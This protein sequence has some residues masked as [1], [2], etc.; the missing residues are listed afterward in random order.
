MGEP[1]F[2]DNPDAAQKITQELTAL[3][4]GIETYKNLLAKFDDTQIFLELALE[5]EDL[6]RKPTLPRRLPTS[7]TGLKRCGWKSC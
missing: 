1:T 3:K 7:N 6:R 5:E 4:S 2:W